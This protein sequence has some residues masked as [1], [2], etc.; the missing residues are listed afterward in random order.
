VSFRE[1]LFLIGLALVPLALVAYVL[2]QRRRRRYAVRYPGTALLATVAGRAWGRHL[3]AALA[4]LALAVL[5]AALA[6]PERVVAAEERQGIVMMVSDSSG[7]MRATDVRPDRLTAAKAAARILV[8]ELPDRFRLGLVAF[9]SVAEQQIE[10]TLDRA[11]VLA[12]LE[13]LQVR[14]ATAMGDG[15]QLGL[16]AARVP[17]PS[18][19]GGPPRRLPAALVLLSDGKNTRGDADPIAV[20]R[21]ARRLRVRI[22]AVALGTQRGV[23]TTRDPVTGAV[24]SERVPPD[25]TTLRRIARITRGQFFTAATEERLRAVYADLGTQVTRRRERQEVTGAFTGGGLALLL[26]G[27]VAGLLRTG[28]LP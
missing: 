1:P 19:D 12:A 16:D 11:S 10:P 14:G 3:P 27:A 6:R 4:L 28:R 13:R 20:A 21:A 15:L 7:S 24:S 9:G 8:R 2:A 25:L 18:Q 17:L 22:F 5:L 23:L 26:L